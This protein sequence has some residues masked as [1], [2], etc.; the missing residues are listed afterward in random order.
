[1]GLV[2]ALWMNADWSRRV[3][4][5]IP[6]AMSFASIQIV[7]CSVIYWKSQ[8]C[9]IQGAS[10]PVLQGYRFNHNPDENAITEKWMNYRTDINLSITL[11]VKVSSLLNNFY[12]EIMLT[13]TQPASVKAKTCF[14]RD[15][16]NM[17]LV[18]HNVLSC[19]AKGQHNELYT[20]S[21]PWLAR[22]TMTDR[23]SEYAIPHTLGPPTKHCWDHRMIGQMLFWH[24]TPMPKEC[25]VCFYILHLTILINI[26]FA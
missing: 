7:H 10:N 2:L 3:K 15:I 24:A 20:S 19:W 22:V 11:W 1:M 4:L 17:K 25:R 13:A 9:L 6:P 12:P 26:L 23:E 16:H 14:I 8:C 5:Q 21:W 18:N